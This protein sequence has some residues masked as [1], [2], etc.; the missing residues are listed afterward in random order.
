[1]FLPLFKSKCSPFN[2]LNCWHFLQIYLEN[3][4]FTVDV[5]I[6][7]NVPNMCLFSPVDTDK[8]VTLGVY[9]T[10]KEQKK[11]RR[12]TRR[13]AQKELQERVRL[14]LMPPPEPKGKNTDTR[15]TDAQPHGSNSESNSFRVSSLLSENLQP[16]EG[17]GNGGGA[18]PHQ[19][20]GPRTSTD[21]Q[22]AE[23]SSPICPF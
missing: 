7:W 9:L 21:G 11:L 6:F 12:Q 16:D 3:L 22:E 10:K 18:G 23:V 14:G 15:T 17:A 4:A 1:M 2:G 20:G 5:T 19:G 13:E 8:T